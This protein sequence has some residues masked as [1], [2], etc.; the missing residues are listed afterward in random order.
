VE[1]GSPDGVPRAQTRTCR[2]LRGCQLMASTSAIPP[3][4]HW[5]MAHTSNHKV[6]SPLTCEEGTRRQSIIKLALMAIVSGVSW[7]FIVAI[8]TREMYWPQVELIIYERHLRFC[9]CIEKAAADLSPQ[10]SFPTRTPVTFTMPQLRGKSRRGAAWYRAESRRKRLKHFERAITLA[11]IRRK[12]N[13]RVPTRAIPKHISPE[14]ALQ[15]H[16]PMAD[17]EERRPWPEVL[18]EKQIVA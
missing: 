10:T 2:R 7:D 5:L 8:G 13:P 4:I 1:L 18:P 11:S 9:A 3:L 14:G 17:S 15:T 12:I 16:P 6:M